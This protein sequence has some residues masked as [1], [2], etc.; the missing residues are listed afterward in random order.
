M[1]HLPDPTRG[2]PDGADRRMQPRRLM[3]VVT[4]LLTGALAAS[5]PGGVPE[6]SL[7]AGQAI[8]FTPGELPSTVICDDLSVLRVEDAGDHFE[9]VGLKPGST[10]C[11]F[12]P[13]ALPGIRRVYRF[14]VKP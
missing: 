1:R 12:S 3:R 9:I 6:V 13:P 11:S 14:D 4:L 7:R 8:P 2:H 5:A 10:L